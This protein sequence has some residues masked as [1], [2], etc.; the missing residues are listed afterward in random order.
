MAFIVFLLAILLDGTAFLFMAAAS[1]TSAGTPWAGE[2]APP[3]R[4]SVATRSI[5]PMPASDDDGRDREEARQPVALG[6]LNPSIE[7]RPQPFQRS[8]FGYRPSSLRLWLPAYS[9]WRMKLSLA[10]F[11]RS[12]GSSASARS[13][14]KAADRF[15]LSAKGNVERFISCQARRLPVAFSQG[16]ADLAPH[17]RD[18]AAKV[19]RSASPSREHGFSRTLALDRTARG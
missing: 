18:R 3:R 7:A 15:S 12:P 5:S 6:V 14:G 8:A 9:R 11:F 19:I 16:N 10:H 4:C 13:L 2:V 1:Q 17:R